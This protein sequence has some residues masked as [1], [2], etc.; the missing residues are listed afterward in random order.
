MAMIHLLRSGLRSSSRSGAFFSFA[1]LKIKSF[2]LALDFIHAV[3]EMLLLKKNSL[4]DL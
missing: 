3:Q 1:T 4:K 2:N